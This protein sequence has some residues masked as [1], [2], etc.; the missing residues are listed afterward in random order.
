ML[1]YNR[2]VAGPNLSDCDLAHSNST[3]ELARPTRSASL[4]PVGASPL[5]HHP[6]LDMAAT[7]ASNGAHSLARKSNVQDPQ[8]RPAPDW[9]LSIPAR[10]EALARGLCA[11]TAHHRA[12][13][14]QHRPDDP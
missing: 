7:T 8:P 13:S 6:I 1:R 2:R 5:L 14:P 11:P 9:R 12:R 10:H 4:L 3:Q